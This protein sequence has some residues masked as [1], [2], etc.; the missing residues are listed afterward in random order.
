[1]FQKFL[2]LEWKS[3]FRSASFKMNLAVKISLGIAGAFY[4]SLILFLGVAAFFMLQE[5]GKEPLVTV[6]KFLVYWL[7]FDLVV[8]YFLQQSPILKIKPFLLKLIYVLK[9]LS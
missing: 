2:Y 8:K 3:F 6:N 4:G 5:E 9:W 1:M 7:V